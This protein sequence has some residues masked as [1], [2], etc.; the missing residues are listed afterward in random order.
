MIKSVTTENGKESKLY[1]DIVTKLDELPSE[2]LE[3][4]RES[5][6][7]WEGDLVTDLDNKKQLGLAIYAKTHSKAYKDFF[8][9]S[10]SFDQNGEPTIDKI[11]SF[12]EKGRYSDHSAEIYKQ[13]ADEATKPSPANPVTI[14]EFKEFLSRKNITL[15]EMVAGRFD[16]NGNAIT[17]ENAAYITQRL[18]NVIDGEQ[19][20][21][22]PE[23]ASHHAVMYIKTFEPKL[24][25]E[26]MNRVGSYDLYGKIVDLYKNDKDYQL[27]DGKP[28][29]V[30]LKQETL[31]R[32]FVENVIK[33]S[34][35][36]T[37]KPQ[38]ISQVQVWWK[39]IIESLKSFF[40]VGDF[41]PFRKA[42]KD[43][44]KKE[45]AFKEELNEAVT[46]LRDIGKDED[47]VQFKEDTIKNFR[48]AVDQVPDKTA[49]V[50]HGTVVSL[51]KTWKEH[52]YSDIDIP[53]EK[54]SEQDIDNGHVEE[55]QVD[56]KTIYV[57][58]HAQ[59]EAN[60]RNE[61][62]TPETP[63]TDYGKIQAEILADS[64]RDKGI[65]QVVSTDT[66]RTT[67]T[68]NIIRKELGISDKFLQV[69]ENKG[70][71]A[72][73]T[74]RN[75]IK[76]IK[77]VI[78]DKEN[79]YTNLENNRRITKRVTD[80]AA[81]EV[82]RL[83]RNREVTPEQRL[84]WDQKAQT[85]TRGHAD[86]ND[87]TDR[88]VD[89]QT[90]LA[91]RDKD[92]RLSPLDKTNL[93]QINPNNEEYYHMLEKMMVDIIDSYPESTRFVWED[94]IYDQTNDEV[95]SPD[96]LAILPDGTVDIYDWKFLD[97]H[98]NVKDLAKYKKRAYNIQLKAYANILRKNYGIEKIGKSRI[99]PIQAKY[100]VTPNG[101][102]FAGIELGKSDDNYKFETRDYLLPFP[103][104]AETMRDE[105]EMQSYINKLNKVV[106][107]MASDIKSMKES[108]IKKTYQQRMTD[109][110]K[111]IRYIQVKKDVTSSAEVAL[112]YLNQIGPKFKD[113]KKVFDEGREKEFT[114]N[115]L[116]RIAAE[117]NEANTFITPFSGLQHVFTDP[118][119]KQILN[120][121]SNRVER[122]RSY[123]N[124]L[125]ALVVEK[126]EA[127]RRNLFGVA[128]TDPLTGKPYADAE[129]NFFQKQWSPSSG[130]PTKAGSLFHLI[131]DESYQR[132]TFKNME[133]EK[134]Y[135]KIAEPV[136]KWVE[137]KSKSSLE[138]ILMKQGKGEWGLHD[139]YSSEFET[140]LNKALSENSSK[141]INE[142]IR[143]KDYMESYKRRF[144]GYSKWADEYYGTYTDNPEKNKQLAYDA[145]LEFQQKYDIEGYP[146]TAIKPTNDEL[147]KY[148]TDA[149]F[150][151]EY[152]E[153]LRP[154]NKPVLDLYKYMQDRFKLARDMGI[155]DHRYM[156][157]VPMA[158]KSF[159]ET[160]TWGGDNKFQNIVRN[161]A[162]SVTLR[163][164]DAGY[165]NPITREPEDKLLVRY[166]SDIS[167]RDAQGRP[168]YSNLS[169][170][171]LALMHMFNY[172]MVKYEY[173]SEVE[174]TLKL[175]GRVE[176]E[177]QVIST[178]SWGEPIR[179]E[180]EL[181]LKYS[182]ANADFYQFLMD[183]G[184]YGK[185]GAD[186]QKGW[187]VKWNYNK[188]AN[189]VNNFVGGDVLPK[190]KDEK[191]F[192]SIPRLIQTVNRN[193]TLKAL[194][195]NPLSPLANLFGGT[196]Q[197][198]FNANEIAPKDIEV[199]KMLI[200]KANF[201]STNEGKIIGGLMKYFSPFTS[202]QTLINARS[203]TLDNW[204]KWLSSH[205]LMT[206]MRF[207]DHTVEM[208]NSYA[209]M[210]NLMVHDGKLV[211]I[212]THLKEKYNY[213]N[214][215]RLSPSE[216]NATL[217]KMRKELA[218]LKDKRSIVKTAKIE[219]GELV[220]PDLK[221]KM[222]PSVLQ[223]RAKMQQLTREALG[224]RTPY[225][226][227]QIDQ[228][229]FGA[230][231]M[232]FH[233][234]I[235]PLVKT[236]FQN[237][238][239]VAGSKT[240][241]WGRWKMLGAALHERGIGALNELV[242][243]LTGDEES[244][245]QTGMA[246]YDKKRKEM[247]DKG[248][249]TNFDANMTEADF[250]DMYMQGMRANLYD[251]L[252][253]IALVSAYYA[254]TA[255][256]PEE[257]EKNRGFYKAAVKIL[258]KFSDELAFFYSPQSFYKLV[259]NARLPILSLALDT[260]KFLK[261]SGKELFY[262]ITGDT[263][264]AEKNKVLKYPLQNIPIA[265]QVVNW[266]AI[267]DDDF[268]V[269]I[270]GKKT[271]DQPL[272]PM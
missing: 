34:E 253:T 197:S 188:F 146:K 216:R 268:S 17:P 56:G 68:A 212:W 254:V 209:M 31:T 249:I 77:H 138:K 157:F 200:S 162:S 229:I 238:N 45:G 74:I 53:E 191:V 255:N 147:Y 30:K 179:K 40:A 9:E 4:L 185:E 241:K 173:A 262:D 264:A 6:R 125:S 177:K 194:G 218:E 236:R 28:D 213:A 172:E 205:T 154:E 244:I 204:N 259:G 16:E 46:K 91:R 71:V 248:E 39:R 67:D 99:I 171:V 245:R 231:L 119:D 122:A 232:V 69:T 123:I 150:S 19:E 108:D 155:L 47:Y 136:L 100:R 88:Y 227:M 151:K 207:S 114:E 203:Y 217:E 49:I 80:R 134:E 1:K 235:P 166:V 89:K 36:G 215:N 208:I 38:L 187:G 156:T 76:K 224:N 175:I 11:E 32:L 272:S 246:L 141:W 95:G 79:Y 251:A 33:L 104:Q 247:M 201:V 176:R 127:N 20:T 112:S 228:N 37:E 152:K 22:L 233:H 270:K 83:F 121:L 242:A 130:A 144:E 261:A 221:D 223:A 182:N 170:D 250:V 149:W 148:P 168:D 210:K 29:I 18:V 105:P 222:D 27:P 183:T 3:E 120:D 142:N 8:E 81:E 163:P 70:K 10:G 107:E 116:R 57:I 98:E 143:V 61:E 256:A 87:I 132:A 137:G 42:A 153:L 167:A 110:I 48:E 65:S 267:F 23:E 164:G 237:L 214:I 115:D 133:V 271:P 178:N 54:F 220:I 145:K 258:D 26:M 158:P 181:Q 226:K 180:G 186:D 111:S 159:V 211:H 109:L 193:V 5:F 63:L 43:F 60:A 240:Y 219:N 135:K 58:R 269:E 124:E 73:D 101:Y 94:P 90:G 243:H 55:L 35:G 14:Q 75:T 225:E 51:L 126:G 195:L 206:G 165:T 102:E 196:T 128:G 239:Y 72:F 118:Q 106:Q 202:D 199:G 64:L 97:I 84:E 198:W 62:S 2:Q 174:E 52:G 66:T 139:K 184:F 15:N 129:I 140:A 257:D 252:A 82:N 41:D 59:S 12:F 7:D 86:I 169:K 85:G 189:R 93:S 192:V 265:S 50:T 25:K 44:L 230:S 266:W 24:F 161:L 131:R 263:E 234:W 96:F 160:I 78:T 13:R 92:A 117:L 103:S 190:S 113:Y 21:A 260:G